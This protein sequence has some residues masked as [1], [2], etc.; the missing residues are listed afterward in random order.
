MEI[1]YEII[2]IYEYN[3]V[4]RSIYDSLPFGSHL[5]S[6]LVGNPQSLHKLVKFTLGLFLDMK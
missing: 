5:L 4:I 6:L 3:I 1:W 2:M